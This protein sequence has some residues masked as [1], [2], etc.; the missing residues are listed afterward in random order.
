[1]ITKETTLCGKQVTLG[2]CYATEIAYKD[3]TGEDITDYI[4]Q[5]VACVQE[6]KDPDIKRTI[7]A[8]LA[9][10][11]AY[12]DSNGQTNPVTDKDLMHN[13]DP[14]EI[15]TAIFT[16]L[17]LRMQFYHVPAGEPQPKADEQEKE[18]GRK[19]KN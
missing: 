8:I 11:L 2:Y 5:A 16:I 3:L 12:Y 14:V 17:D 1:M 10:M 9:C 4:K 6:Q 7:Y 19:A 15:G 18:K 13:A